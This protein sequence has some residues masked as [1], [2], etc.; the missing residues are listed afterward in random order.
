MPLD[1]KS[2]KVVA[3][4]GKHLSAVGSGDKTQITLVACIS[5]AGY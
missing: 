3:E 1:A 2:P 5:A 4:K